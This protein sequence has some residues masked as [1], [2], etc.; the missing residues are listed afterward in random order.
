MVHHGAK[1]VVITLVNF[2]VAGWLHECPAIGEVTASL[3]PRSGRATFRKR[4]HAAGTR[5]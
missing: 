4:C 3:M 1:Y 5:F 2:V